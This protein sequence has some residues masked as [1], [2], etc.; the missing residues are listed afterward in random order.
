[1]REKLRLVF[2]TVC[3]RECEGCCNKDYDL[4]ALPVCTDFRGYDKILITGGEPMLFPYTLLKLVDEIRDQNPK[5]KIIVYTAEVGD[6]TGAMAVLRAVDGMTVTVHSQNDW[7]WFV[8]FDMN[9]DCD[10][11]MRKS[12]RLNI[13]EGVDTKSYDT[14]HWQPK[15]H[16]KWV[17][18]CPLPDGE[19][20]MRTKEFAEMKDLNH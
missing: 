17:K 6:S 18:S 2:T 10:L 12:L 5:C 8:R 19:V 20:L 4:E 16:I 3:L 13:F 1:M 15:R 9:L 11:K 7:F 14:T